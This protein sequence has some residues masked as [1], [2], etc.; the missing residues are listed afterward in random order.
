MKFG[1]IAAATATA[2]ALGSQTASAQPII[3]QSGGYSPGYSLGGSYFGRGIVL[4]GGYSSGP[5]YVLPPR[6][7]AGPVLVPIVPVVPYGYG[8]GYRPAYSSPYGYHH[9]HHHHR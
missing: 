3:V 4:S 5:T 7:Y 9:H 6:I 2:L 1:L 8:Y